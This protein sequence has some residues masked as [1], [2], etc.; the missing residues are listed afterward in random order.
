MAHDVMHMIPRPD[1]GRGSQGGD[2]LIAYAV[3]VVVM[4][5]VASWAVGYYGNEASW[6]SDCAKINAHVGVNGKVYK[7]EPAK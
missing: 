2:S 5:S 6:Q 4:L 1:C 3:L 7:C